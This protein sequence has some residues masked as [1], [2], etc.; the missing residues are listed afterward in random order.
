MALLSIHLLGPFHAEFGARPITAFR[1]GKGR[2]LLAYLAVEAGKPHHREALAGL[3]WPD[4]PDRTARANLRFAVCSLRRAI[5]DPIAIP[6]FLLVE[7]ETIQINPASDYWLDVAA[8]QRHVVAGRSALSAHGDVSS[9][10]H[11]FQSAV[12][13]YR[14]SFLEGFSVNDSPAIEEWALLK[15]EQ[16]SRQVQDALRRL[17]SI[18]EER[19][20]YEQAE[21]YARRHLELEPWHEGGHRQLMRLLALSGQ[22]STALAQYELCRQL[23]S[24]ELGVEPAGQTIA[25]YEAIHDGTLPARR[26]PSNQVPPIA[27]PHPLIRHSPAVVG[28]EHQ[29]ARLAAH[30][31]RA[32]SGQGQVVFVAGDAGSGKTMLVNE[33]I[34]RAMNEHGD[35]V[36][37]IGHCS[38]LTPLRT[39]PDGIGDLH[40]PFREILELLAGDARSARAAGAITLEHAEHIEALVPFGTQELVQ[41]GPEPIERVVPATPSTIMAGQRSSP[42]TE[43][44][45]NTLRLAQQWDLATR[46][47]LG[48]SALGVDTGLFDRLTRVLQTLA[49]QRTLILVLEDLQWGDRST[50]ALF[51]HLG[52]RLAGSHILIVAAYRPADL[53][54]TDQLVL[55]AS[56]LAAAGEQH[57]L[58]FIVHE[59]Q[60]DFGDIQINLDEA[61]GRE[62]L[63]AYLDAE[64]NR[65]GA[66]FREALYQHTGGHPLFTAE[67]MRAFQER[68]GLVKDESGRWGEAPTLDWEQSP[69]R[70]EAMITEHISH[71]APECRALLT[72]ASVEG[73]EFTS[74]VA[75]RVLNIGESEAV[76]RMSGPLCK[77]YRLVQPQCIRRVGRAGHPVSRYCFQQRLVQK[78]LYRS[79]DAIERAHLHE[80]VG[81]ALEALY[82]EDEVELAAEA[83]CL[84]YHFERSGLAQEAARYT[85]I[86]G[87][88]AGQL[89]VEA[90]QEAGALYSVSRAGL[91]PAIH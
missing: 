71:L 80:A 74:E 25:L 18:H 28:R 19:A 3:L 91:E 20:E 33:F 41:S 11:H 83:R 32:R 88:R 23:M 29:L 2:A 64:P 39:T 82:I 34:R 47:G 61:Q 75:A 27:P 24:R 62:F 65:L 7:R 57:P 84:A 5:G 78:H 72:V 60:R 69:A 48:C 66:G 53:I 17:A 36:A 86:A 13:L 76:W 81:R 90:G 44:G 40:T 55:G 67:L 70:V 45:G 50:L 14:G 56:P 15:R 43:H 38:K 35:V 21:V 46:P 85:L 79:L 4:C 87:Q 37:A 59:F 63:D 16:V 6:P 30:L 58:E 26:P 1:S 52:R 10:V 22:R 68:G 49:R 51:F 89:A 8:L 73:L 42:G 9:A 31:E 54:L 77:L 12:D